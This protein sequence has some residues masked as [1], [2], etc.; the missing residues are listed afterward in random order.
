MAKLE[1]AN[2]AEIELDALW[3]K[4]EDSAA[5]IEEL[6][7]QF[8]ET[9]ELIDELCRTRR[10]VSHK[11]DF[12]VKKFQEVWNDGYTIYILKIWPKAGKEIPYR[13]LY[14]HHP[15]KDIYYVLA[16]MAREVNYE[17]DRELIKRIC[18]A[19]E[20]YGIPRYR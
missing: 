15:Q 1:Y 17:A 8:E 16:V 12:E 6:L 3:D 2:E 13:I 20:N 5:L 4:D 11:P 7:C 10:H 18:T 19:Y 14:G 9:P